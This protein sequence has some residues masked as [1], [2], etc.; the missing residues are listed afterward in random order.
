MWWYQEG[1]AFGRWSDNEGGAT[2][3]DFSALTKDDRESCLA[4]STMWDHGEKVSSMWLSPDLESAD[5]LILEFPDSSTVRNEFLLFI[6]YRAYGIFV[7]ASQ[8]DF[9]RCYCIRQRLKSG[10][11]FGAETSDWQLLYFGE[12]WR[13]HLNLSLVRDRP[14][15]WEQTRPFPVCPLP[16]FLAHLPCL[17]PFHTPI[18]GTFTNASATTM[19]QLSPNIPV[20]SHASVSS[21]AFLFAWVSF[22]FFFK[23]FGQKPAFP[24]TFDTWSP[25]VSPL[26]FSLNPHSHNPLLSFCYYGGW[27]DKSTCS[28]VLAVCFC[29]QGST[30]CSVH[31][32][33]WSRCEKQRKRSLRRDYPGKHDGRAIGCSGMDYDFAR[34]Q[35]LG[36]QGPMI[37]DA[38][39]RIPLG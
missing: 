3:N 27:R 1:G 34:V 36:S 6:S 31:L 13:N 30:K 26:T 5:I 23:S 16:A 24:S 19:S 20:L 38:E 15:F 10:S 12:I 14:S 25:K 8:V 28:E 7:I 9:T 18:L 17:S 21:Q 32:T 2:I 22:F 37:E 33:S 4:S 39:V 35:F 11:V 29:E